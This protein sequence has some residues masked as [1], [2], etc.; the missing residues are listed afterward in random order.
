MSQAFD[1][2]QKMPNT[3]QAN[4]AFHCIAKLIYKE[5]IVWKSF[6]GS[7]QQDLFTKK[8]LDKGQTLLS[9]LVPSKW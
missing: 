8:F 4:Q 7:K 9:S 6:V 5:K 3:I 1:V 2:S